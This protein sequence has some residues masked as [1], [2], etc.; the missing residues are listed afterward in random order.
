MDPDPSLAE[1]TRAVD[2]PDDQIRLGR[3]A[4]LIA[5]AE[6]PGLDVDAYLGRLD[7]L[8]EAAEPARRAPDALG[9]LH[10]LREY[11]FEEQGFTGD[12]ENYFDPRNSHL[13]EVLE[14]RLGIP[15]SLS[16]VLIEVGRRLD[17]QM[18]GIG[19]PGHFITGA[20]VAGE[21]VLLDPFNRG[22]L[23]TTES[24]RELVRQALGRPVRLQTE[25]FAPVSNRQFLTRMLA[26]LKG[27]YWRQEAWDK[28]VR[29]I[30]RLLALN[31]GSAGERRDRGAAWSNMG[32]LERGV[33]D[34]EQYLTEF[35]NAADHEQVRSQL[36]RVRQKLAQLN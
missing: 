35:P 26:N 5:A 36:R 1:F 18:E 24:C 34:W 17:L 33:A 4:L 13:N 12:R 2:R 23:L 8:A 28:V 11:L 3:A 15:I 9:R 10:R 29:V 30:D 19:L 27:V 32:R 6:H 7:A 20:R 22:A 16:L 21:Q 25:H 14:R 31:P